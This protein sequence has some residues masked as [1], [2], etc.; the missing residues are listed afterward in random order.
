VIARGS[1]WWADLGLPRGS[2]PALRRPVLIVSDDRFNASKLRTVT[3]VTLT[4]N[5]RLAAIPGN[6][7]I[8][9]D[10]SGLAEESVANVTQLAT[11]DRG[12][13][14]G[15]AVGGLPAWLMSKVDDGLRVALG[16]GLYA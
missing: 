15:D 12:V 8:P 3:V 1:I 13:L 14:D 10:V 7:T 4:T 2:A 5:R 9:A 6:V 16:L 11:V